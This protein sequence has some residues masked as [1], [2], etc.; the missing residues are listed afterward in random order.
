MVLLLVMLGETRCDGRGSRAVVEKWEWHLSLSVMCVRA[1]GRKHH[2]GLRVF[3]Q[4]L[5][6]H[7]SDGP[8]L[9]PPYSGG[10]RALDRTDQLLHLLIFSLLAQLPPVSR[11]MNS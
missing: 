8:L 6:L 7:S 10:Q 3:A 9:Q 1:A 2:D 4:V 11:E 5:S